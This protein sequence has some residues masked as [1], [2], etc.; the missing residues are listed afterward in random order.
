M[1]IIKLKK[2][3]S[4]NL[5]L[6]LSVS[7]CIGIIFPCI[8][9][10][11]AAAAGGEESE[12][13]IEQIKSAW[14]KLRTFET[15]LR[16]TRQKVNNAAAA[17]LDDKDI[18]SLNDTNAPENIEKNLLGDTYSY[19]YE[20]FENDY[21]YSGVNTSSS[22]RFLYLKDK[23]ANAKIDLSGYSG[24]SLSIYIE[25]I[26]SAGSIVPFFV[27]DIAGNN[28][29]G[30]T[31]N[32]SE[33]MKGSWLTLSDTDLYE[34]GISALKADAQGNLSSLQLNLCSGLTIK[35]ISGS[36]I[37]TNTVS[38][39][40]N[41]SDFDLLDWIEAA[42]NLDKSG[43]INTSELTKVVLSLK[44]K[45]KKDLSFSNLKS[46]WTKL[47]YKYGKTV[48]LPV[49][50]K[51][52]GVNYDASSDNASQYFLNSD[53][54]FTLLAPGADKRS[55]G[56]AYLNF[57][58]SYNAN[59]GTSGDCLMFS[60]STVF[61]SYK[62][63]EIKITD[64][65]DI[66]FNIYIADVLKEG[67]IKFN[68]VTANTVPVAGKTLK[69]SFSDKEKWKTVK[70]SDMYSGDIKALYETMRNKDIS[71]GNDAQKSGN[72]GFFYFESQGAVFN[73]SVGSLMGVGFNTLPEN[74][75][76]MTASDLILAAEKLDLT[77]FDNTEQFI[78]V[79]NETKLLFKNDLVISNL[80]DAWKNLRKDVSF[81]VP[82]REKAAN[83]NYDAGNENKE[84]YKINN[85]SNFAALPSGIDKSAL[86]DAFLKF[87][88][89]FD[90]N[91]GT[92]GD[93]LMLGDYPDF[94]GYK[95]HT[96]K[97]K[98]F[99]DMSLS[100]YIDEVKTEGN[101]RAMFVSANTIP[102]NGKVIS[103]TKS[104]E[105]QWKTFK[106]SDLY[107][108]DIN[109][110]Y[111]AML[112]KEVSKGFDA[113]N[114]GIFG[115]FYFQSNG[116]VFK[117]Y[118]GSFVCRVS[119]VLP[120]NTSDWNIADWVY[121]AKQLDLTQYCENVEE[122]KAALANAITLRDETNTARSC[123]V[124]SY[125]EISDIG[126]LDLS[127][128]I[129]SE[130]LPE[131]SY[132]NGSLT[133]P[134]I[135]AGVLSNI[136]DADLNSCAELSGLS[137]ETEDCYTDILYDLGGKANI[138]DIY[139]ANSSNVL[140]RNYK[141]YIFA[142]KNLSDLYDFD[143][144]VAAY[145]NTDNQA[146]QKFNFAK[147]G[148]ITANYLAVR[149]IKPLM[150]MTAYDGVVRINEIAAIGTVK[151][152]TV[153]KGDFSNEKIASIGKSLISN[154]VASFR[155]ASGVKSG[156]RSVINEKR[157]GKYRYS[158][159]GVTDGDNETLNCVNMCGT[160]DTG[161]S[162]RLDFY[163][164]LD[165]KYCINKF[166]VN[167]QRNVRGLEMGKFDIYVSN[168]INS[169]FLTKNKVISFDNTFSSEEGTSV[170]NLITLEGDG[171]IGK[172]VCFSFY[173]H[174][175]D[176]EY[177][178]R[179]WGL[180]NMYLRVSE[181]GV[182]GTE[183]PLEETNL[184]AHMP[185]KVY[186]T[187]GNNKSL[188]S[189]TEYTGKMHQL[190]YDGLYNQRADINTNN[191]TVDFVF[192]LSADQKLNS[193]EYATMTD[194]IRKLKVYAADDESGVWDESKLVYTYTGGQGEKIV[195][196]FGNG[197]LKARYLRFSVEQTA[198]NILD[199]AEIKA[200]GWNNQ[201]FDYLNVVEEKS[202][203]AFIMLEDRSKNYKRSI[204]LNT[205]EK[206]KIS[207]VGTR[208][209]YGIANAFDD[210]SGTVYDLYGGNNDTTSLNILCDLEDTKIIES[211]SVRFGANI[212]YWPTKL[213]YYIGENDDELFG[214]DA[215]P[216]AEFNGKTSD[217]D[218]YYEY[219]T[220]PKTAQYIR[221]EISESKVPYYDQSKIGTVIKD[222]VVNGLEFRGKVD[223]NGATASFTNTAT[224]IR[225]DIMAKNENDFY[226]QAKE[227][228][229]VKRNPDEH[230]LDYIK[231]K[232][233][234]FKSEIY[235]IYL[236]DADGN[237]IDDIDSRE[238]KI[239]I[240][241]SLGGGGEDIFLMVGDIGFN[242]VE[243][244][245]ENGYFIYTTNDLSILRFA[246]G[247]F[248]DYPSEDTEE[249]DDEEYEDE[250]Y[251]DEEE[252]E[253]DED[254][255]SSKRR[256]KKIIIRRGSSDFEYLWIII[257]AAAVVVAG[258][259]TA[260]YFL[261]LRKKRKN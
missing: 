70:L 237:I 138:T 147:I 162:V 243:A 15:G 67:N 194:N 123:T 192:N 164:K 37:L 28:K 146:V 228:L 233:L 190:I 90:L 144:L 34:G 242:L 197:A 180:N 44:E 62:T 129:L 45:Y 244:E 80:K 81:V 19:Y 196:D 73:G 182:Y 21:S 12:S 16:P 172:Y 181:L 198:G 47:K 226:G 58:R 212:K 110:L 111:S 211:I 165:G 43:F 77:E 84:S 56:D 139:I 76:E 125:P 57:Q 6:I 59:S 201:E 189:E 218:G 241:Q 202:D 185:V 52:Q 122:F 261:I 29:R 75:D 31:V 210:N 107:G 61:N 151:N 8:S 230:D 26:K 246:I 258:A 115:F 149:M 35:A 83:K 143:N 27:F 155:S 4:K 154:K 124:T 63:S 175:S 71:K 169:L 239:Y 200:T 66:Y 174:Y 253:I 159:I 38:L 207:F 18:I 79:L 53:E 33:N 41:S 54:N 158:D 178:K 40:A 179:R 94:N 126:S 132:Y 30:K 117:G 3:I 99:K 193:I 161:E 186:R 91:S 208:D 231:S 100:V 133:K 68:F 89:S 32:I 195:K 5:A 240:P 213:K 103:I 152:Y 2:F 82:S 72:L 88:R 229:V 215:K 224:G 204:A 166:L 97:F 209:M 39:P 65:E 17:K 225:L 20:S 50:E 96:T 48:L 108:G 14:G 118:I 131:V 167:S 74:I 184:L 203:K 232:G 101:M 260:V 137:Y 13:E 1:K 60:N 176:F 236:L 145:E 78:T 148:N 106:L 130:K 205:T 25:D 153:E 257:V 116:A 157:N 156:F 51:A 24:F 140:L 10:H 188:V 183:R 173:C 219:T 249:Y 234:T 36:L 102:L 221:I 135:S 254:T 163:Y 55:L 252:E 112:N 223:E 217:P 46:A 191:K 250:D 87:N 22:E 251:D 259:G 119:A 256:V 171:V 113:E 120:E 105:K 93:C 7:L 104:D 235:E 160:K 168:D 92:S 98:D 127:S 114:S 220:L 199:T 109:T 49:R 85:D 42:D 134:E 128:D 177:A 69:I 187:S 86:G 214:K 121:A 9:N 142:S 216:V 222:I 136:S 248:F 150:D 247:E 245:I 64:F 141:Y 11:Y 206:F 255:S 227:M 23:N 170:S 95:S 238:M